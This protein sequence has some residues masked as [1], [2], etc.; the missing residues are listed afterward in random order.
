MSEFKLRET[1]AEIDRLRKQARVC[2]DMHTH[3]MGSDNE[4]VEV[5][6]SVVRR[7]YLWNKKV[8]SELVMSTTEREL[9]RDWLSLRKGQLLMK[10]DALVETLR[11]QRSEP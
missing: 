4:M 1:L 7:R 3:W 8:H 6:Q 9:F 11:A 2:E 5:T 10:A